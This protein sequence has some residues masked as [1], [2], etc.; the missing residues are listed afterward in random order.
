M[1]THSSFKSSHRPKEKCPVTFLSESNPVFSCKF[2][3]KHIY[4]TWTPITFLRIVD[5]CKKECNKCIVWNFL[6][7]YIQFLRLELFPF[8]IKL[9]SFLSCQFKS[10]VLYH[11]SFWYLFFYYFRLQKMSSIGMY[12]LVIYNFACLQKCKTAALNGT[13]PRRLHFC[14]TDY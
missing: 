11:R 9:G 8:S 7:F 1:A 5:Y 13:F 6:L 14:S 4:F 10:I 12:L 2:V 3:N